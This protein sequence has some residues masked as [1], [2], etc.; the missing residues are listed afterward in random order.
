[1]WLMLHLPMVP[2]VLPL[3]RHHQHRLLQLQSPSARP[4]PQNPRKS[5]SIQ[6]LQNQLHQR[7]PRFHLAQH[8]RQASLLHPM[9][10]RVVI[11]NQHLLQSM[12]GK[13]SRQHPPS[14]TGQ[15][16]PKIQLRLLQVSSRLLL[17]GVNQASQASNCSSLLQ[18]AN[19]ARGPRLITNQR[20][21][22]LLQEAN[23]ASQVTIRLLREA[24]LARGLRLITN[25]LI[26]NQRLLQSTIGKK[27]SRPN[28]AS[29]VSSRLLL[30]GANQASQ[31]ASP[32]RLL[33]EVNQARG[34]LQ[35]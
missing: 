4:L 3:S 22:N 15:G 28:Q 5:Q 34:L 31:V 17:R 23:Q 10:G 12:I 11:T 16:Q 27:K 26:T 30:L 1:M 33:R 9:I 25:Q 2:F 20:I 35:E 32:H 19:Q 13:T 7:V 8:Q 18:G 14:M 29:Q 24:N 21:T 6:R